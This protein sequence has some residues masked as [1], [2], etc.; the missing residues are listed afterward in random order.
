M[1]IASQDLSFTHKKYKR[2]HKKVKVKAAPEQTTKVGIATR[3]VVDGPVIESRWD[4]P[5]LYRPTLCP[6]QSPSQW[7]LALT[8]G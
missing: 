1:Y 4:F 8:R 5:Q 2:L 3:Y 7:L 6:T